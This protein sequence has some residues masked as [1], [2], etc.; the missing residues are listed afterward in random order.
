MTKDEAIKRLQKDTKRGQRFNDLLPLLGGMKAPQQHRYFNRAGYSAAN[1]KSLEYDIKQAYGIKSADLRA[2][3]AQ[4]SA[5]KEPEPLDTNPEDPDAG[6]NPEGTTAAGSTT[7]AAD[8][9]P[10]TTEEQ[11]DATTDQDAE[12]I[13]AQDSQ[14][15]SD[16]TADSLKYAEEIRKKTQTSD[17]KEEVSTDQDI[18]NIEV[19]DAETVQKSTDSVT[20]ETVFELAPEEVKKDVKLRERY[21]FLNEEETPE[22]FY[23][24]VGINGRAYF[25]MIAAREELFQ[26]VVTS[27]K[28]EPETVPM[29]NEEIFELA[30]KAVENFELNIQGQEELDYYQEHKEV[31]GQHP[32]FEDYM[33][34]KKV[35]DYKEKDLSKR[36]GLLKNYIGR[37][38]KKLPEMEE[39]KKAEVI[40]KIKA[41]EKELELVEARLELPNEERYQSVLNES[42]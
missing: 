41:W 17:K 24:L 31:L 34:Q 38:S 23:T 19:K 28:S 40:K 22:E 33:L 13:K 11:K 1:L 12:A 7:P 2:A 29:T 14:S 6:K 25:H 35:A 4:A 20:K 5:D 3:A 18:S 32:I 26:K 42:I 8:Q 27:D 30:A 21:P 15:T 39:K 36:R 37:E 9:T 16:H 10:K